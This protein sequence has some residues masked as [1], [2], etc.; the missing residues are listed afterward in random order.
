MKRTVSLVLA[1]CAFFANSNSWAT[2]TQATSP[3]VNIQGIYSNEYGGP[4]VYFVGTVNSACAGGNGLY[5]YNLSV[6][7]TD[8][9]IRQRRNNK[10]ATVL[11]AKVA[12][13]RVVLE[14]FYDPSLSG[15]QACYIH[16]IQIVD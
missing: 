3:P 4:F 11:A 16:G 1:T 13:K 2:Y 7:S 12:D 14:Y 5:L 10:M 8:D 6:I 9:E 15:W